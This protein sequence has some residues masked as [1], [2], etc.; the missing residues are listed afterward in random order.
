MCN[1]HFIALIVQ[2]NWNQ[3]LV[4][5]LVATS[6]PRY[7]LPL[8]KRPP[9]CDGCNSQESEVHT[10]EPVLNKVG[11]FKP[12]LLSCIDKAHYYWPHPPGVQS[13][14]QCIKC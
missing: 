10:H 8:P 11:N 5:S 6:V 2:L 7:L 13:W 9:A 1:K 4:V 12:S 14:V 3:L